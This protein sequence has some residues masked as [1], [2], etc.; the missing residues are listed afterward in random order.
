[1]TLWQNS[2]CA[3]ACEFLEIVKSCFNFSMCL[4]LW[5]DTSNSSNFNPWRLSAKLLQMR[6]EGRLERVITCTTIKRKNSES[7]LGDLEAQCTLKCETQWGFLLKL[8]R[9]PLWIFTTAS[10]QRRGRVWFGWTLSSCREVWEKE[11]DFTPFIMGESDV[12]MIT[13]AAYEKL[14]ACTATS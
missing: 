9:T 10:L 1:M 6:A 5:P 13:N 3:R 8:G 11:R 14:S 4:S 12:I 2:K 7:I